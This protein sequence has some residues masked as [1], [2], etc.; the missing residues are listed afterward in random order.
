M[1]YEE[2]KK[3]RQE[4]INN[5]PIF[6]AFSNSQFEKEMNKRGLSSKDTDKIYKLGSTGGFYLKSDA[7]VIKEYFSKP[8]P[9][10]ELMK[11]FDF[12]VSAFYHEMANHEYHI[13]SYQGDWDVCSVFCYCEWGGEKTYEEYLLEG[14]YS[15]DVVKAFETAK[16]KF[17]SDVEKNG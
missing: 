11:D 4:E 9:I 16:K 6:Y 10:I 13:N 14:G 5:L 7:E 17:L 8:D 3:N 12:A 1:T 2:Y 15:E